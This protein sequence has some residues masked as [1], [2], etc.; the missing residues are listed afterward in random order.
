MTQLWHGDAQL[1]VTMVDKVLTEE[2]YE[3][4]RI[5]V[6]THLKKK[7]PRKVYDVELPSSPGE[8]G[9]EK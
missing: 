1:L 8:W 9:K 4:I 7:Y 3:E 6:Q 2:D 5:L